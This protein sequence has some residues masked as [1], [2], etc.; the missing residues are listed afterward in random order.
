MAT[1]GVKRIEFER[2]EGMIEECGPHAFFSWKDVNEH[3]KK[4]ARTA[5]ASGGYD[6][7]DVVVEWQDGTR[8]YIRFDMERSHVT[9]PSP[10]SDEFLASIK[11]YSGRHCPPHM[12][13]ADY[14][15]YLANF[16]GDIVAL[17]AKLLDGGYDL[18][19]Q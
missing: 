5:P 13:S 18:G 12:T 17:A 15:S 2:A 16:D 19:A 4:A 8:R 6:K 7:C 9:A 11:F 1:I 10:V 14:R 3:V